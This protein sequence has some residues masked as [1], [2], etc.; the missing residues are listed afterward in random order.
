MK[1]IFAVLFLFTSV[2]CFGQTQINDADCATLVRAIIVSSDTYQKYDLQKDEYYFPVLWL[3]DFDATKK[4]YNYEL[5]MFQDY[6]AMAIGFFTF[7]GSTLIYSGEETKCVVNSA[8]L[9]D[10]KNCH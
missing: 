6:K 1:N 10:F 4:T 2:V 9:A 5:D 3:Q 7:N 8:L